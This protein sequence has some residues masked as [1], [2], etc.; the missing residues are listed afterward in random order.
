MGER[1]LHTSTGSNVGLK[2]YNTLGFGFESSSTSDNKGLLEIIW[3]IKYRG[4]RASQMRQEDGELFMFLN[5]LL[6]IL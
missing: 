4:Q 2:L 3:R 1:E 6:F 5:V